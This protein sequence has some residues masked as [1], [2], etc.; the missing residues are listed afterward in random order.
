MARCDQGY[1]CDVCGEEVEDLIA[2]ELPGRGFQTVITQAIRR[3]V[4]YGFLTEMRTTSRAKVFAITPAGLEAVDSA[5]DWM[6]VKED[7]YKSDAEA[8]EAALL[9]EE[10]DRDDDE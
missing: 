8:D 10:D 9:A 6:E 4:G 5:R 7:K 2:R 3:N 1:L